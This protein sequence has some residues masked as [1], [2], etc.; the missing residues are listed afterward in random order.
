[1][2]KLW[3]YQAA[4][5]E[6]GGMSIAALARIA[7]WSASGSFSAG[8]YLAAAERGFAHLQQHNTSYC[9]DGKENVIDDYTALMAASELFAA[10]QKDEY[11]TAARSRASALRSRLHSAGY[12][13]ADDGS[14]PFWHARSEERRVGERVDLG[15]GREQ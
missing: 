11:L 4:F 7:S 13:I 1:G 5:R 3:E 6:G 9:D 8:E 2:T 15:G 14:R 12:F 10:T